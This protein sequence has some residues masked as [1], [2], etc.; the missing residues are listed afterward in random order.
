MSLARA[1]VI[2]CCALIIVVHSTL[3]IRPPTPQPPR[4][5]IRSRPPRPIWGPRLARPIWGQCGAHSTLEIRPPTPQPKNKVRRKKKG[6]VQEGRRP[7]SEKKER[8]RRP[9]PPTPQTGKKKQV[10]RRPRRL[11]PTRK[12]K[13]DVQEATASYP[14]VKKKEV[15]RRP[16]LGLLNIGLDNRFE[17]WRTPV[18]RRVEA[19]NKNSHPPTHT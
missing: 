12:K 6:D 8:S 13:P 1:L 14:Q 9:R 10:P 2:D 7:P 17:C 5:E 15:S 16:W 11:R 19:R 4:H 18:A 3:E